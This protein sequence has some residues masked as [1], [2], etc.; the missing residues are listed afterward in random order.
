MPNI[1]IQW[2]AGRT[3]DL[4]DVGLDPDAAAVAIV[5]RTVGPELEGAHV[6]ERAAVRAAHVRVEA[7]LERHA[8]DAIERRPAGLEAVVDG[9]APNLHP[10][11]GLHKW[12]VRPI[13]RL[14]L[15][16]A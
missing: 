13:Q 7:P 15:Q 12:A 10:F 4:D 5:R 9:H 2:F 8:G 3:Q 6:A 1:T 16:A 11:D 14:L